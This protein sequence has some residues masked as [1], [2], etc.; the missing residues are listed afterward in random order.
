MTRQNSFCSNGPLSQLNALLWIAWIEPDDVV[1]QVDDR[2]AST[3]GDVNAHLTRDDSASDDLVALL[4]RGK[5]NTMG[6]LVCWS[7]ER[8]RSGHNPAASSGK[9]C[10]G[11]AEVTA[12]NLHE[13]GR[14]PHSSEKFRNRNPVAPRVFRNS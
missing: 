1:E 13:A 7:S 8:Y 11:F 6:P 4:V 2:P 5:T 10:R 3:P 12:P 14:P 9:R